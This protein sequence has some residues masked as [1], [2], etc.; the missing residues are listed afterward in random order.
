M[1]P[2]PVV[3]LTGSQ[4]LDV[5]RCAAARIASQVQWLERRLVVALAVQ[6]VAKERHTRETL[7]SARTARF[8]HEQC[9]AILTL[10][11]KICT[12]PREM[13]LQASDIEGML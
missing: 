9:V 7:K 13:M 12:T 3:P 1:T 4:A 10:A 8:Y 6:D 2:T 11:D 5:H